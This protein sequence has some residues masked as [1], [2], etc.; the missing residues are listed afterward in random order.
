MALA[1]ATGCSDRVGT[2]DAVA[3]DP[4]ADAGRTP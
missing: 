2:A 1:V 3:D 4:P